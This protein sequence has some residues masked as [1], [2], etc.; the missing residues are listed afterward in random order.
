MNIDTEMRERERD[1][2]HARHALRQLESRTHFHLPIRHEFARDIE[3]GFKNVEAR[4]N[5]GVAAII[6]PGDA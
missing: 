5:T 3:Q 1:G 6:Q 4:I 2:Q